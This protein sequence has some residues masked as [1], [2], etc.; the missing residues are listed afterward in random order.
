VG[1]R[2]S[3][4]YAL[5]SLEV[6]T[7]LSAQVLSGLAIAAI[8][9]ANGD[10]STSVDAAIAQA[11][12]DTTG[13]AQMSTDAAQVAA[14]DPPAPE[15]NPKVDYA[16]FDIPTVQ[17]S[18]SY[19]PLDGTMV[20]PARFDLESGGYVTPVKNQG[21]CGSCWA[22][23]TM[24]SIESS[25]LMEGGP[26]NDFSENNLKDNHGFDW[27]PCD[28]GNVLMS[29]AYLTR[30][31]GPVSEVADPYHPYDDRPSPGGPLRYYVRESSIFDTQ[32]QIKDALMNYGALDTSMRWEDTSY[33]PSDDTY[34]YNGTGSSNHDVTIVGW[35]NTKKTAA[36]AP[37]AW[38]IKN[39]WGTS[40]GDG[41]YFWLS[42]ADTAG[43]RSA[44]SFH[45]AVAPQTYS[46]IYS[47]DEFGD[48]GSINTPYAFSAF[49]SVASD[50]LKAV[51][52]W[53]QA[54]WAN[55]DI[56][57]YG[58]FAGGT[59]SNLLA[60]T[61]GTIVYA[62]SHTV[63]L[64]TPVSLRA[65]ESFYVYLGMTNGGQY[66]QTID[67]RVSGYN[68]AS[69]AKPGESYYSFNGQSWTDLTAWNS[70][71]NFSIKA[72]TGGTVANR[73]PVVGSLTDSPDPVTASGTVTLTAND[74]SDP[75]GTVTSVAFYRESNGTPGL[76]TAGGGDTLISTDTSSAG[77]W[78]VAATTTGLA[79]GTYTYYAQATDN[80][81][82]T[83]NV[84][85]TTNTVQSIGL[86]DLTPYRPT[87]WSAP[88]VISTVPGTTTDAARFTT[89]DT[90]YIDWAVLNQGQAATAD[91]SWTRL[92]L[93]GTTAGNWY[94]DPP[95][96]PGWYTYKKDVT[97]G[98]LA[99]GS[100]T[101]TVQADWMNAIPESDES[102]NTYSR[103]FTV[104]AANQP[105][106]LAPIPNQTVTAGTTLS[107]TASA[108]D[109]DSN[110]ETLTFSLIGAP[111][112]AAINPA[113][114]VFSWTP[115]D[116]QA[117]GN[118]GFYVRVTDNGTPPLSD[119]R[120]VTIIVNAKPVMVTGV[121]W[122]TLK[123]S[124]KKKIKV[125]AVT[126]S[127]AL[128]PGSAGKLAGYSLG[129]AGKDKKFGTRDDKRVALASVSH[130]P[131]AHT[132]MLRP[133]GTVPKQK[134]QLRICA[135]I[136]RDAQGRPLDGDRDGQPGGDFLVIC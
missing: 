25:I 4:A 45:D 20:Y 92:L 126:F 29:Q 39:S 101:L 41:G 135:A 40:F 42:Y 62:G 110:G 128:D 68:S 14:A 60:S 97:I 22:F 38:L 96:Q 82:A 119:T 75:D 134:L 64:P 124:K 15:L 80:Q 2:R 47:Y 74:V 108:T 123:L 120:S 23:A 87:G 33:R 71:A 106:V 13:Q 125:L 131:G 18:T 133:R 114:G 26:V 46:H 16:P 88:I 9:P 59:L 103:T 3:R 104:V 79:V 86:P 55:Y 73:P 49:T 72:L 116:A 19:G 112:G 56:R 136:V 6:R 107:F 91:R 130:N 105:P 118:Y 93:N 122:D 81:G 58:T 117:P 76:Q 5:E 67:Y 34:Y 100:Y 8:A 36:T 61:T 78:T 54:D 11:Q 77:G 48:V 1:R 89:A 17:P 21:Q 24:A 66:P 85:S 53:T 129:T 32:D 127:G 27:G 90:V 35:D 10:L 37:G 99:A 95:L 44:V 109:P 7:L 113:T 102:N 28:G 63:D 65:G 30:G 83:S 132:V 31:S 94:T 51:Q 69:M 43:G 115:T 52:F 84:V 57:I 12:T 121:H 70:T 98:P 50:P 111:A